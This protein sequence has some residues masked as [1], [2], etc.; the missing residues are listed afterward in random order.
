MWVEAGRD[1]ESPSAWGHISEG[2]SAPGGRAAADQTHLSSLPPQQSC[3]IQEDGILQRY[4][5]DPT[6]ALAEDNISDTF[7]PAPGEW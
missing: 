2:F 5:S 6:G 1:A 4:S 7:L 3:P